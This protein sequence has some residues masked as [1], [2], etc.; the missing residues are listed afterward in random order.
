MLGLVGRLVPLRVAV[1][2]L[3]PE[4]VVRVT[5]DELS[6]ASRAL[7]PFWTVRPLLAR[8]P[9]CQICTSC[10]VP[11]MVDRLS[12]LMRAFRTP[13]LSESDAPVI[14][15]KPLPVAP[16]IVVVPLLVD[17]VLMVSGPDMMLPMS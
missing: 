11:V 15:R 4:P 7:V 6:V 9:P 17:S 3:A 10:T 12:P 5:D 16:T 14:T 13:P 1:Q 2:T 8:V